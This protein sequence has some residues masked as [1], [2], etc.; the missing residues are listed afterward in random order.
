MDRRGFLAATVA[1]AAGAA[2]ACAAPPPPRATSLGQ[3]HYAS[4]LDA[5]NA[6]R[7]GRV[8]PTELTSMMLARIARLQPRLHAYVTVTEELAMRQAAIADREVRDG[9]YRG[10]L[11][12]IPIAVKDLI[13]TRG[14]LT[15]AEMPIHAQYRPDYNATVMD[16]LE[17]AGAILL[18]KLAM[19]E[20]AGGD[21]HPAFGP[22]PV[23][24]WNKDHSP[25]ASSSGPGVATAAGLCFGS[26][27]SDT[28]GSIR[29]PAAA[30]GVTGIKPTWGRVS[31]YGVFPLAES[32]DH[33]GPMARSAADA[34][35]LLA[36]IAGFDDNDP[37]TLTASVPDYLAEIGAGVEGLRVGIDTE[38]NERDAVPETVAMV[39]EAGAVLESLGAVTQHVK[40]PDTRELIDAGFASCAAEA[41]L[42]HEATYPSRASEY[43]SLR[44]LLDAGRAATGAE[45][46][47]AQH[48][49]V[50]FSRG[51]ED[52][53]ST[54]DVL[55]TPTQPL[56]NL[57]IGQMEHVWTTAQGRA[58]MWRFTEP[59]NMSGNPTIT[60]PGGFTAD[61]LPLAF[62]LVARHLGES[63]LIRTGYAY[64]QVTDWHCRHPL[65]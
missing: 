8:S 29:Y 13:R 33:V 25:G 42:A 44:Q 51:L 32:L 55:L 31:R 19:T 46:M 2:A 3:A 7:S 1:I 41:A 27:G 34:A 22:A 65:L 63:L 26:I 61:G 24:P 23:N 50:V 30:N 53:F 56:S 57:T 37:T 17:R 6:V 9:H 38:Y 18:G 15:T 39:R 49:R 16:R 58:L 28:T 47:K 45:V 43:G 10:P 54:I 60:L 5:A 40:V 4:L 35:A 21:H 20:G 14:V 12:G 59:F 62:Q 11:H 36:A 64:Q 52:L 48:A